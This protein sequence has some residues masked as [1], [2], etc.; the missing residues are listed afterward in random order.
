[1]QM[2]KT[3][4]GKRGRPQHNMKSQTLL[5]SS[6]APIPVLWNNYINS[7]YPVYSSRKRMKE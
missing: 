2:A 3:K 4:K 1:M 6:P 5:F 7:K